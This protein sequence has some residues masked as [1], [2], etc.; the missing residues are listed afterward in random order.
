MCAINSQLRTAPQDL[1]NRHIFR[2]DRVTD[3]QAARTLERLLSGFAAV[4][5]IAAMS[6]EERLEVWSSP[7]FVDTQRGPR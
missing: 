5:D 7:D 3:N 6:A 1:S 2:G 4:L